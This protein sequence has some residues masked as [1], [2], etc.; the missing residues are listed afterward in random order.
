MQHEERLQAGSDSEEIVPFFGGES[1]EDPG[2]S[3]ENEEVMHLPATGEEGV[4]NNQ[5][6]EFVAELQLNDAVDQAPYN[7]NQPQLDEFQRE[8]VEAEVEP[9]ILEVASDAS[10]DQA[11]LEEGPR[12]EVSNLDFEERGCTRLVLVNC[13]LINALKHLD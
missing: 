6:V 5:D 1:E 13:K 7:D 11:D 3:E 8:D 9:I 10:F 4:P 12:N 2:E